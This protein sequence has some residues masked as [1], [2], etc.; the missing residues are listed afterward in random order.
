[1]AFVC[2]QTAVL[3]VHINNIGEQQCCFNRLVGIFFSFNT[4]PHNSVGLT[5][6]TTRTAA[7]T[8]VF[9]SGRNVGALRPGRCV[10]FRCRADDICRGHIIFVTPN[11]L[12]PLE[13]GPNSKRGK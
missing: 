9:D 2:K 10:G 3:V 7:V 1:M 12:E 8:D 13:L 11:A 6:F 4:L 5:C